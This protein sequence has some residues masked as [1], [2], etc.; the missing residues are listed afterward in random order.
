[1][2]GHGALWEACHIGQQYAGT[3]QAPPH[4]MTDYAYFLT[5]EVITDAGPQRV[6]SLTVDT[7]HAREGRMRRALAH[8]DNTGTVAAYVNCGEDDHGIWVAGAVSPNATD[9]QVVAL[10]GSK[11]SG[12]WRYVNSSAPLEC[13]AFLAV[14]T[15]GFSVPRP[16]IGIAAGVQESLVA[17]GM[18]QDGAEGRPD[19][20]ELARAVEAEIAAREGR[21]AR[22]SALALRQDRSS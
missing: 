7:G 6:G 14:N 5:G 20:V 4:S 15:G 8:Y 1:M 10:R 13:V 9:G 11:L 18:V 16:R 21:R 22:L 12:D 3:C 2:F 19:V 17:A